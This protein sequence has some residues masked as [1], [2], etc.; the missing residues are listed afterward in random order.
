[1]SNSFDKLKTATAQTK[2][3]GAVS[4]G[5]AGDLAVQI[6]SL[7]CLP[8]DPL[9]ADLAQTVGLGAWVGLYQTMVDGDLD[10]EEGDQFISGGI[11]Y[12]VRTVADW[13]WR[14]ETDVYSLIVLE[15]VVS[16]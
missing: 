12:K 7:D 1:M 15:E 3:Q 10:I 11:T 8:V 9:S 14:P 6:E 4:D 16:E 13:S 5:L 2:R